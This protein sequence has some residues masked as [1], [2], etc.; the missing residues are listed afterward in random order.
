MTLRLDGRVA[1]GPSK[2]FGRSLT[3]FVEALTIVNI[4]FNLVARLLTPVVKNAKPM[5]LLET[6]VTIYA[7]RFLKLLAIRS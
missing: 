1:K 3:L 6:I 5:D 7:I 2:P 4:S